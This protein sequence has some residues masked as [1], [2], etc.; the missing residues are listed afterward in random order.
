MLG[1]LTR[2]HKAHGSLDVT[3]GEGTTLAST[4][5]LAGLGCNAAE[6]VLNERVEDVHALGADPNLG[7]DLL[8]DLED[9]ELV[10]LDRLLL[11]LGLVTTLLHALG[12]C[13]F[14]RLGCHLD[15]LVVEV[16]CVIAYRECLNVLY[17]CT[18][19]A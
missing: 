1:Q 10:A 17:D 3:R 5:Q 9:V 4:H 16:E 7:V 8:Q 11:L 19:A 12:G 2:Q 13:L 18:A 14:C 6:L 15:G